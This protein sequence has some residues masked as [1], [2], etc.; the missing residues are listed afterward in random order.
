[1]AALSLIP[2]G[3]FFIS[4]GIQMNKKLGGLWRTLNAVREEVSGF[5]QDLPKGKLVKVKNGRNNGD[6]NKIALTEQGEP[7][8]SLTKQVVVEKDSEQSPQTLQAFKTK[9][10]VED[11]AREIWLEEGCPEGRAEAHWAQAERELAD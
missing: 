4:T 7:T 9:M 5:C 2:T 6:S 8:I 1:M 10:T 3:P 11:R